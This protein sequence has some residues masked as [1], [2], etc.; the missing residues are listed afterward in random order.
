M[1]L[2]SLF[3]TYVGDG[4]LEGVGVALHVDVHVVG[5]VVDL[6]G[7]FLGGLQTEVLLHQLLALQQAPLL[8][9][10]LALLA[11]AHQQPLVLLLNCLRERGVQFLERALITLQVLLIV[12]DFLAVVGRQTRDLQLLELK[13][14]V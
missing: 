3:I 5:V 2:V 11:A 13:V 9:L 4:A 10:A 1:F 14:S 6:E 8:L 12:L 7:L